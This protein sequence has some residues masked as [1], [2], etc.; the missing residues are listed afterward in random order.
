MHR[1]AWSSSAAT[2]RSLSVPRSGENIDRWIR[3]H[4]LTYPIAIDTEF[5]IW[6]ALDN[7]AWPAK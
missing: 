2:R 7:D 6:R 3:D 1:S 5:A 4:G